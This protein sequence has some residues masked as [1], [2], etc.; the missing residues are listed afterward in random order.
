MLLV[1]IIE[2]RSISKA[3]QKLGVTR[4]SVSLR[5][6]QMEEA[7]GAQLIRRTTRNLE[8]TEAGSRL[9]EHGLK[10]RDELS[11]AQR[12]IDDLSNTPSGE[13][14]VCVPTGFGALVASEWIIDFRRQ[15]PA[16]TLHVLFE[17]AVDDLVARRIDVSIRIKSEPAPA[18]VARELVKIKYLACV[19]TDYDLRYAL[20][21]V[22]SDLEDAPLLTSDFIGSNLRVTARRGAEKADV[23]VR[24]VIVSSNFIFIRDAVLAGL[25]IGLLPDYM[26]DQDIHAGRIKTILDDWDF[27][28]AYGN[29]IFL[30]RMVQRFQTVAMRTF[31]AFII[32]KAEA[33]NDARRKR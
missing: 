31:V 5:L 9:Y 10:I 12:A 25:G 16:I 8:P 6:K 26:V 1:D 24:P 3:A 15:H 18:L 4:A 19:S 11:A 22:L 32:D 13:V 21:A 28:G 14:R 30:L 2:A 20:P 33:Y 27:D 23:K 7:A 29:S 17:N